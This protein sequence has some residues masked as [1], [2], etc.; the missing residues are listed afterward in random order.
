MVS[1]VL[2]RDRLCSESSSSHTPMYL[3][4]FRAKSRSSGRLLDLS[5]NE[6]VAVTQAVT[7]DTAHINVKPVDSDVYIIMACLQIRNHTAS[8][9]V[10]V[11]SQ[12]HLRP[13]LYELPFIQTRIC[14]LW[15][16]QHAKTPPISVQLAPKQSIRIDL[17]QHN[18]PAMASL[19]AEMDRGAKVALRSIDRH[20][21]G[22]YLVQN[23]SP[24]WQ[25]IRL[26]PKS[27]S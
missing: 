2:E 15:S 17:I 9:H 16:G 24:D 1:I 7:S 27:S 12:G 6:L 13:Y 5:S 14:K 8:F 25:Y 19:D 4:L 10:N 20:D 23:L 3:Y 18:S 22:R 11:H 21:R 26:S